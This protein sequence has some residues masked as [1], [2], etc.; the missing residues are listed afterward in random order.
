MLD[1]KRLESVATNAVV[2]MTAPMSNCRNVQVHTLFFRVAQ[3]EGMAGSVSRSTL[4]GEYLV[5]DLGDGQSMAGAAP[6]NVGKLS[7]RS[8]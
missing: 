1:T 6:S 5:L 8:P 7:Y 2:G 4:T 3:I